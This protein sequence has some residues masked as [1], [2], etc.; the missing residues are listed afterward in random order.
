ML[1][2][3]GTRITNVPYAV[4][5]TNMDPLIL[6]TRFKQS[7]TIEEFFNSHFPFYIQNI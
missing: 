2:K 4:T 6:I 5:L 3:K 7:Y 1:L